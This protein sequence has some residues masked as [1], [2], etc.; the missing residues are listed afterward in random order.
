MFNRKIILIGSTFQPAMLVYQRVFPLFLETPIGPWVSPTGLPLLQHTMLRETISPS[1]PWS[2]APYKL[3]MK[4]AALPRPPVETVTFWEVL[5]YLPK[6]PWDERYICL[7][8]WLIFMVNVGKYTIYGSYGSWMVDFFLVND[9]LKYLLRCRMTQLLVGW[10][11]RTKAWPIASMG[12]V[13][14]VFTY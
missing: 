12:L 10:F 8:E 4:L 9:S 14:G 2:K 1:S 3:L 13:T 11:L 5:V 7:H 6:D